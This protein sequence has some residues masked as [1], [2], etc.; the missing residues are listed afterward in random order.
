MMSALPPES[1]HSQC[2]NRCPLCA[3]SGHCAGELTMHQGISD[4]LPFALIIY[5]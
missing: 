1:G 4:D 3:N 5:L 2:K